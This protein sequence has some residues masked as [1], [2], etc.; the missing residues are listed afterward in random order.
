MTQQ[1]VT[2]AVAEALS[3]QSLLQMQEATLGQSI[4]SSATNAATATQNK[5]KAMTTNSDK[6]TSEQNDAKTW[7]TIAVMGFFMMMGMAAGGI[8]GGGMFAD[9]D[10]QTSV[11]DAKGTLGKLKYYGGRAKSFLSKMGKSYGSNIGMALQ[12]IG[13]TGQGYSQVRVA[14]YMKAKGEAKEGV[15]YA[16]GVMN[17]APKLSGSYSSAA[18]RS[19][20]SASS[21]LGQIVQALR[22]MNRAKE[23]VLIA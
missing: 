11:E 20:T 12:L 14:D 17:E 7:S 23:S 9:E 3:S 8:S 4:A 16:E 10:A 13:M 22:N 18:Q 15:D 2:D 19:S 21:Q 1:M 6:M 5:A